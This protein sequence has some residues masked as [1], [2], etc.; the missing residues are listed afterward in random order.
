MNRELVIITK[1]TLKN[2]KRNT[3]ARKKDGANSYADAHVACTIIANATFDSCFADVVFFYFVFF[4]PS[5][6]YFWLWKFMLSL[7]VKDSHAK[8][9]DIPLNTAHWM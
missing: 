5:F 7:N 9:K 8:V 4:T 3:F 6:P 1:Y 2:I